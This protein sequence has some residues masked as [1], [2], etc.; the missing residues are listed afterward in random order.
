MLKKNL[1]TLSWKY[2]LL[3][4]GLNFLG[5]CANDSDPNPKPEV[6]FDPKATGI[7][8]ASGDSVNKLKIT[9]N[10]LSKLKSFTIVSSDSSQLLQNVNT[11]PEK[12]YKTVLRDKVAARKRR[13]DQIVYTIT[14]ITE[15]DEST[16]RTYTVT[17]NH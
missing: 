14:A 12:S 5:S 10:S 1:S 15:K 2:L 6:N 3:L 17:I 7:F 13:G 8:L 11:F 9:V 16:I 4:T